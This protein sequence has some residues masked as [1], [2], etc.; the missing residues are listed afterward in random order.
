MIEKEPKKEDILSQIIN[1]KEAEEF[2]GGVG[3]LM[4]QLINFSTSYLESFREV[5]DGWKTQDVKICQDTGH[6]FKGAVM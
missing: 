1:F 2:Y 3:I 4:S 5:Q 6:K